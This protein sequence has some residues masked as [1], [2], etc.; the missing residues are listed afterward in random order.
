MA[1]SGDIIFGSPA[2]SQLLKEDKGQRIVAN[3]HGHVHQGSP[4]D[5]IMDLT[6]VFNPGSLKYG[7]F[8]E[9]ILK[10]VQGV[11]KVAQYNKHYLI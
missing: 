6:K 5:S 10:Q 8:A 1:E 2:L 3:I 7:E 9:L 4:A 11:W